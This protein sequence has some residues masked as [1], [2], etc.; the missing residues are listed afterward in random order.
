MEEKR[1][2][3]AGLV[4]RTITSYKHIIGEIVTDES[5]NMSVNVSG[6]FMANK[7]YGT[8][9]CA[10]KIKEL[11]LAGSLVSIQEENHLYGMTIEKFIENADILN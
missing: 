2:N 3:T 4:T 10:K 9:K 5:G 6:S 1:K 11:G 8:Y 7:K